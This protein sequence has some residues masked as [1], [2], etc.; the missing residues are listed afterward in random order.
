MA[1]RFDAS[2]DRITFSGAGVPD[3]A[4]G[5]TVL[6]WVY[7][8]NDRNDFS[9][10]VRLSAGSGASTSASLATLGDGTTLCYLTGGGIPVSNHGLSAGAW[11][12]AAMSATGSTGTIYGATATGPTDAV[13]GTVGGAASPDM[14]TVGGR[15]AG[16]GSEWSDIRAAYLRVYSAQLT[17]AEIETEW[18]SIV[19]VR[20]SGLWADYPLEDAADLTDHSGNGRHL[21]AGGTAVTTEPGPPIGQGIAGRFLS[22]L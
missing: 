4:S 16:D 7:L 5:F 17:Q 13:S 10:V 9:T 12:R 21:V 18:G 20:T 22:F 8:V 3:P 19:P 2:T 14:L 11:S 15:S 6:G 1:V